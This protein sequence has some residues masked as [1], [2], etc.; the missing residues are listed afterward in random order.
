MKTT[1]K[2]KIILIFGLLALVLAPKIQYAQVDK[3]E[4][5]DQNISIYAEDEPLSD[6]IEKICKYL[7]L[8]WLFCLFYDSRRR[9]NKGDSFIR[10][11]TLNRCSFLHSIIVN[12]IDTELT[13]HINFS[14]KKSIS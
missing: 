7:C 6:V 4:A 13:R 9:Q 5:L 3:S 12:R 10:I 1:I 14:C 8:I 2:M 11:N